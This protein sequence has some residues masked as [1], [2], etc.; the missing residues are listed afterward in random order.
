MPRRARWPRDSA[1]PRS[2]RHAPATQR[3]RWLHLRSPGCDLRLCC[4]PSWLSLFGRTSRRRMKR[5]SRRPTPW[6]RSP[7]WPI[8]FPSQKV[9]TSR[10]SPAPMLRRSS[11]TSG[12]MEQGQAPSMT[13]VEDPVGGALS[14][15]F[16]R[17]QGFDPQSKAEEQIYA[18]GLDQVQ[19]LADAR[20]MRLAGRRGLPAV[21]G[22]SDIR[23]DSD[24]ELHLS[25]R[26][27]EHLGSQADG[28]DPGSGD[29]HCA[30][31]HRGNGAPSQ[32]SLHQY[33]AFDLVLRD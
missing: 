29:R 14:T 21:W 2:R 33:R 15:I 31:H 11:T 20:R 8:E 4:S 18:E 22:R 32:G 16:G 7:G 25:L 19:R 13:Q 23:G 26:S 28:G 27:G 10:N 12:L 30:V 9:P 3:R 1:A 24:G 6:P 5:S 17:L